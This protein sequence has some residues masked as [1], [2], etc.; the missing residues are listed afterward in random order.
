LLT[1]EELG[2]MIGVSRET[3]TRTLNAL[4]REQVIRTKDLNTSAVRSLH[5]STSGGRG[6][7]P[8][9]VYE[10]RMHPLSY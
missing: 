4:K 2:Q 8:E 10:N 7:D 6:S 5:K 3:V 9:E 1:H